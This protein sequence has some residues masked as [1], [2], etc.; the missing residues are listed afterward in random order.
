MEQRD[1]ERVTWTAD[2]DESRRKALVGRYQT[3]DGRRVAVYELIDLSRPKPMDEAA[4]AR[5]L[6]LFGAWSDLDQGED[7]PLEEMLQGRRGSPPSPFFEL[8]E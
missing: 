7:D 4:Q 8:P 5:V 1:E 2:A 6:A 3:I